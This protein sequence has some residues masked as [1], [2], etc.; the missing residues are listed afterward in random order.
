[1]AEVKKIN[2]FLVFNS[3]AIAIAVFIAFNLISFYLYPFS[4]NPARNWLSDLGDPLKNPAGWTIYNLGNV[5]AGIFL[6]IFC[7]SFSKHAPE[8]KGLE[9]NIRL[10]QKLGAAAALFF[11][12][13]A[14]V[15]RGTNSRWHVIF[16]MIFLVLISLSFILLSI[17]IKKNKNAPQALGIYGLFMIPVTLIIYLI[18]GNIYISEFMCLAFF[19]VYIILIS[20]KLHI[21]VRQ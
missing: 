8:N 14:I 21:V 7:S 19:S 9:K 2:D 18:T 1:M 16:S 17:E 10:A 12:M 3:G 15:P 11:I 5:I 4:Y 20:S 6:I 13:A